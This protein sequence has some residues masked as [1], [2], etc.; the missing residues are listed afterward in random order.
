MPQPFAVDPVFAE[1]AKAIYGDIDPRELAKFSPGPSD[2]HVDGPIS[3]DEAKKQKKIALTGL[4][5]TGV[6]TVGGIHAI[7]AS[8]VENK[9]RA[10]AAAAG[11]PAAGKATAG[12]ARLARIKPKTA[13][14]VVGGGMLALHGV[15][16][17]GDSLGARAQIKA[18][19][20]ANAA[21]ANKPVSK[22]FRLKPL[23]VIVDRVP[24]LRAK[25]PKLAPPSSG[26]TTKA[27]VFQPVGK[28]I[29]SA[30]KL[31]RVKPP[32]LTGDARLEAVEAER[33]AGLTARSAPSTER[34]RSPKWYAEALGLPPPVSK[35]MRVGHVRRVIRNV[36]SASGHADEAAESAAQAS[37]KIAALI[38]KPRTAAAAVGGTVAAAIGLPAASSYA[39][40]YAGGQRRNKK[41][42]PVSKSELADVTWTGQIAKVDTDKRQVF[43]WASVSAINGEDVVDLQGDIVPI[44]EVEK[45]AYRYVIESRKGGDM[46]KRVSKAGF[47]LAT[48]QPLHTADMIE[49]FVVTPEKLEKMGLP[50][51]AL[52]H[53]WWVGYHVNDDAQWAMVKS[54]ERAGFSI[55][56]KGSRTAVSKSGPKLRERAKE[57]VER[58]QIK[59]RTKQAIHPPA[60]KLHPVKSTAVASMG[61]QPQTKRL[62]YEMHSRPGRPYDYRVPAG[63]AAEA[64]TAPSIG[65]H[66]A[67]QVRGKEPRAM[68]YTPADRVRLFANPQVSKGS[69]IGGLKAV[70]P[71]V[72]SAAA[73][74]PGVPP[75]PV[76]PLKA[77]VNAILKPLRGN[78]AAPAAPAATTALGAKLPAKPG[79]PTPPIV[80][81]M[82]VTPNGQ[83][84]TKRSAFGVELAKGFLPGE[85]PASSGLPGDNREAQLARSRRKVGLST[86]GVGYLLAS[87]SKDVAP[88]AADL[89]TRSSKK[90]GE[91]ERAIKVK[92]RTA[93]IGRVSGKGGAALVGGGLLL[94][95]EGA[96]NDLR[97]RNA[98]G[99]AR[100]EV[101]AKVG[102]RVQKSAFGV[103][104]EVSKGIPG[105]GGVGAQIGAKL[106]GMSGARTGL[107]IGAKLDP[108]AIKL[109]PIGTKIGESAKA[110]GLA[111]ARFTPEGIRPTKA[112]VGY[113][114]GGAGLTLGLAKPDGKVG[115][116]YDSERSR[117][118]RQDMYSG[119]A[120][121]GAVV[122]GAGAV[123]A[124]RRA[125]KAKRLSTIL[126]N[127]S[128]QS[129][130][131]MQNKLTLLSKPVNAG[132]EPKSAANIKTLTQ[133]DRAAA[134]SGKSAV[135]LAGK[136]KRL[137]RASGAAAFGAAALGGAAYGLHDY[138]RRRGGASYRY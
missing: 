115:K 92:A 80:P 42:V 35:A 30:L 63:K 39:G 13:A 16:L 85:G 87:R 82:P 38:P 120:T 7:K 11:D 127:S 74:T 48:D 43:G 109:K 89:I 1:I 55:H 60:V 50:A 62:A 10:A 136:A 133:N 47:A 76:S 113:M 14:A 88:G 3:A 105:L 126:Q 104:H 114:A 79:V 2:V 124:G 27:G 29:G 4:G 101:K 137:T 9:V 51:N 5:A 19:N 117:H 116:A 49:S 118:G 25:R 58:T 112:G 64:E 98:H 78:S 67:T 40:S 75:N 128:D 122:A 121:G 93:R 33:R 83:A 97:L 68:R 81:D 138:D 8:V 66:Y 91:E 71:V 111:P 44:D 110:G 36:E 103:E 18:V 31:R 59:E 84:V 135:K 108:V 69:R 99:R 77:K 46:H 32:K 61:Y 21:G 129:R 6:A 23:N 86:A 130:A 22:A 106:A 119:A 24:S 90:I 57:V 102:E 94:A 41:I 132:G 125:G 12:I 95:G 53:G 65:H 37:K 72:D 100:Q 123:E 70:A 15:E 34:F 54:G 28:G 131:R 96:I 56:G 45:S 26:P 20:A 107:K 17:L 73:G 52:P 134:S